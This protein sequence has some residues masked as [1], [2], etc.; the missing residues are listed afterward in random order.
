MLIPF[1]KL[2]AQGN[3]FVFVIQPLKDT[4]WKDVSFLAKS[5]C[6]RH[7][8]VG[9]DGLVLLLED[10][11]VDARMLIFNSDGSRAAMCGSALRC[12]GLLIAESK[13]KQNLIIN[14]DSG[15]R[16]VSV[17]QAKAKVQA[18][19]GFPQ[20]M[21]KVLILHGLQGSLVDI[22]NLHFISWWDD[23][24][25]EPHLKYGSKIEMTPNFG[26]GINSMYAKVLSR[27]EIQLK[28]WEKGCGATLAC[29]TGA[30]A[31]LKVGVELGF[32]DKKV[33]IH[34]PGGDVEAWQDEAGNVSISGKVKEV[35]EGAYP[36][37]I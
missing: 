3:D 18:E 35:F 12:A 2:Q 15:L 31:T 14:T 1:S 25:W 6:D 27:S 29:G 32:L 36:W 24:S 26:M 23:L 8:G 33:L 16:K 28:I 20:I 17:D 9:A 34:M 5:I 7:F 11:N 10:E 37:K 13:K 30:S 21:E 22:G 4:P 19:I